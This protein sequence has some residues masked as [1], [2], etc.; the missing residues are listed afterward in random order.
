MYAPP[1]F[2]TP[3]FWGMLQGKHVFQSIKQ[4]LTSEL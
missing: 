1:R 4:L 2:M 3:A